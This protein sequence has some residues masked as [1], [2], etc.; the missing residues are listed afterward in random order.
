MRAG[1][2]RHAAPLVL[3][4]L[5]FVAGC[6]NSA[7][8]PKAG[9]KRSVEAGAA[10]AAQ[11]G[12]NSVEIRQAIGVYNL[13]CARCHKFFDPAD[14]DNAEWKSWMTKMSRKARLTGGQDQLLS[15]YLATFRS[16]RHERMNE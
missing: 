8:G 4:W 16:A 10:Q 6:A 1:F 11:A 7:P 3:V 9:S 2:N 12:L 5:G 14:Y 13:K 15:R